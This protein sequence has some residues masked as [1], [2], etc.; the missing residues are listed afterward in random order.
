MRFTVVGSGTL[1]PNDARRS[2]GHLLDGA[3]FS[4]LMDCGSGT[5]HGLQ[6]HGLDWTTVT[7][8]AITHFHTDHVGDLPALMWAMTHAL[9]QP[10]SE[11]LEVLGPPGL[12]RFLGR[13]ADA[14][15]AFILDPGFQVVVHELDRSDR[16]LD[17]RNRFEL[18]TCPT[19]HT[20]ESMAY[21]VAADSGTVSYTGDTGPDDR[22]FRFLAGSDLVVVEC[23]HPDPPIMSNHLTPSGIAALG[24]TADP[25]R[26]V[27]THAYPELDPAS[28]PERVR[29]AGYDGQIIA[30]YDGLALDLGDSR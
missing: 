7:H 14:F 25:G 21:K 29:A 19:A 6:R 4:M 28:V 17:P 15:G 27:T 1:V 22:L 9:S 20:D 16:W 11:P 26:I 5:V 3:A 12:H 2:A 13:L 18:E 24:R 8:L 30:A 10:R 23:S